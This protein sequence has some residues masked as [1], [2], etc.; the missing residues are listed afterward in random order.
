L[1]VGQAIV[2][3]LVAQRHQAVLDSVPLAAGATNMVTGS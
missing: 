3:F 1:T 2:R